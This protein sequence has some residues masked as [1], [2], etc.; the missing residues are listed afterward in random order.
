[1]RPHGISPEPFPVY[2]P[3]L[4]HKVTVAFW[5][6]MS[7]AISSAYSALLSDFCPSGHGF[8]IP[9]SRLYL[10]IQT[11]G[12]A[13]GFVGNYAPWDFHPSFGTCPSYKRRGDPS[14]LR[15]P[16]PDGYCAVKYFQFQN[17]T[18]AALL[19]PKT[20]VSMH[21]LRAAFE[22][23]RQFFS[24]E[25]SKSRYVGTTTRIRLVPFCNASAS[26]Y[27][28]SDSNLIFCEFTFSSLMY[29]VALS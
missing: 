11:L 9:S 23:S 25:N 5:T 10:T 26:I 20:F 7:F 27:I 16:L 29:T 21:I 4:R 15:S 19:F 28:F 2:P 22:I 6:L 8:A 24:I 13:I 3:D 12:V 1:M 14:S 17:A 18:A